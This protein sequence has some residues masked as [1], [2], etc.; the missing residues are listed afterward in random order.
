MELLNSNISTMLATYKQNTF[1]LSN[2]LHLD[3]QVGEISDAVFWDSITQ[4][5][6]EL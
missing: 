2:R 1:A 6:L 3:Q 5:L 4:K